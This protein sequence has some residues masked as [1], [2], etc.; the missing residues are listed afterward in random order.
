MSEYTAVNERD[1][2]ASAVCSVLQKN[3][4]H[5]LL[6]VIASKVIDTL[7]PDAVKK[8]LGLNHYSSTSDI[9]LQAI[10][11]KFAKSA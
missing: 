5:D 10:R 3:D 7:P 9:V 4:C 8:L 6:E 11:E 1:A 2:L